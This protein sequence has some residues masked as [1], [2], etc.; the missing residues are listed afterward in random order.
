MVNNDENLMME[1]SKLREF[2]VILQVVLK[3]QHCE[4][5]GFADFAWGRFPASQL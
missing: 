4:S 1:L 5:N 3:Q 2:T